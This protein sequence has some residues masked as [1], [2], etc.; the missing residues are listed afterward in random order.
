MQSDE[1]G[2]PTSPSANP[3]NDRLNF[4]GDRL[5]GMLSGSTGRTS[6][7][8]S[9]TRGTMSSCAHFYLHAAATPRK[10]MHGVRHCEGDSPP[11]APRSLRASL[12]SDRHRVLLIRYYMFLCV[13][14]VSTSSRR[15]E[16][17]G[18]RNAR[19][20]YSNELTLARNGIGN[21]LDW[22]VS[23]PELRARERK[24]IG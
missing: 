16:R 21:Q 19:R 10:I 22:L 14:A 6:L 8:S 24:A 23:L 18:M 4:A 1:C 3:G 12:R 2:R 17:R 13:R 11:S 15:G 20:P 7:S 9:A 5:L